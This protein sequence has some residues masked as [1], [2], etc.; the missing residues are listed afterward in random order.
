MR[1]SEERINHIAA[2]MMQA[3]AKS[4]S[5]QLR[6]DR[7]MTQ[8]RLVK[9]ILDDLSIEAEIDAEVRRRLRRMASAPPESSSEWEALFRREK[10]ALCARKGYVL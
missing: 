5:V 6:G 3:L 9:V 7:K 4:G 8:I 1:L 2:K 10:E